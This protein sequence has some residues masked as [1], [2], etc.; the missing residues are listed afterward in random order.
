MTTHSGRVA[1]KRGNAAQVVL[2]PGGPVG[3][4]L[5]DIVEVW[6]HEGLLDRVFWVPAHLVLEHHS[7]PAR[8]SAYVFG[9]NSEGL[10]E[11]REVA[12]LSTLG[13]ESLDELVVTS[14]R[15]LTGDAGDRDFVSQAAKR[16]LAAIRDAMPL[17]RQVEEVSVGGTRVRSLNLIFA[18]TRVS[19]DEI[20]AL[21]SRDWEENIL[22][23]PEDRQRPNAADRFTDSD[24]THTWA[25]FV[26]SSTST[27]AGLWTGFST[28][29]VPPPLA[30]EAAVQRPQVRVAR[31]FA[32]AVVSGGFSVDLAR[33]VAEALAAPKTPL[34]DPL[35]ASQIDSLVALDGE[36]A[37]AAIG[38]AVEA[39]MR[40]DSEALR[41]RGLEALPHPQPLKVGFFRSL[42][43]FLVF[44][45]DKLISIPRWAWAWVADKLGRSTE[46]QLYGTS[47]D[48]IVD[49]RS[50][51]GIF[52]EDPDLLDTAMAIRALQT[53][54]ETALRQP[55]LPVT[56]R[57]LPTLWSSLRASIFILV[58]GG[59]DH[60]DL[61]PITQ[62]GRVAIV[63][64][65]GMV[66]PAPWDTWQL[67]N[68]VTELLTGDANNETTVTWTELPEARELLAHLEER[69]SDLK[70]R[71]AE[72]E[73][74]YRRTR[75]ELITAERDFVEA[76]QLFEDLSIE[77]DEVEEVLHLAG[78][79]GRDG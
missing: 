41:Y 75:S 17:P 49:A 19:S 10:R 55:P 71:E 23:S 39:L 33:S 32:R 5:L 74:K 28:S 6:T 64:D 4:A 24:D 68:D 43:D 58:D 9:R 12:L 47:E 20:G 35:I 52:N 27:L 44:S 8:M 3:D 36:Q 66:I 18:A 70:E 34:T 31:T 14:V 13:R 51:L 50:D 2:L 59:S 63:P 25:A 65:V 76:K 11:R 62:D 22:V 73:V 1:M 69:T 29:P 37:D 79:T 78:R 48:V 77:R 61:R 26:A 53:Q 60:S 21:V 54:V 7:M 46:K 40:T 56:R 45:W 67:P 57:A 16:M 30:M 15:W 72:L 42:R 38:Q